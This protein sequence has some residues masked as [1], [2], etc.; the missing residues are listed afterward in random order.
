[1]GAVC[2]TC[3][4]RPWPA[5]AGVLP[6]PE[7]SCGAGERPRRAYSSKLLRA[8]IGQADEDLVGLSSARSFPRLPRHA[9][10]RRR[11]PRRR[12]RRTTR[13]T[14]ALPR[15]ASAGSPAWP[16]VACGREAG[17]RRRLGLGWLREVRAPRRAARRRRGNDDVD[18]DG[19]RCWPGVVGGRTGFC[20]RRLPIASRV[21]RKATPA[22]RAVTTSTEA[23][24]GYA[25]A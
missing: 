14:A 24:G 17:R 8:R 4:R 23:S 1:M 12:A 10:Q 6:P 19:A 11:L 9:R 13:R 3:L 20:R 25:D 22:A 2:V 7:P 18:H 15:R 21:I 5:A 16:D